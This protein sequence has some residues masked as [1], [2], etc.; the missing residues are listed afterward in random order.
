MRFLAFLSLFA[1]ISAH[2]SDCTR[3]SVGF[4]P[5]NELAAGLYKGMPGGFYP[6]GANKRPAAHE[7]AGVRLAGEVLPRDASGAVNQ[8][9]GRIVFIS[10]GMSNTT[11]EFSAFKA[12]ADRDLQKNPQLVIVDGAQGG[13]SA[14]KIAVA[15]PTATTYWTV[16]DQRL[17]AAGVTGAQVQAAWMKQA[18]AGPSLAFPADAQHLQA[19]LQSLAQ[20][21]RSRFPNLKLLYLSSRIYAG[22]ADTQLNPEPYAYQGS[23]A[24][25]WAIER[26]I[27]DDPTLSYDDGKAPWMAWGPYLWADGTRMRGDGLTYVCSD[28]QTDGTH[29]SPASQQRVANMLLDFLK[30][31]ATSRTW[32]VRPAVGAPPQVLAGALVNAAS[33]Q[34][35]VSAR[36]IASL[37][38]TGLASGTT[39]A[40][41]LPLP[42][43]LG[44]VSVEMDGV[45]VPLSYVS[46]TQINLL[47]PLGQ[48]AGNLV[49]RHDGGVSNALPVTPA[50]SA[51]GIF[52]RGSVPGGVAAALHADYSQI[53]SASPAKRGETI[54]LFITGLGSSTSPLVRIGG[55]NA[56]ITYAG[57]APGLPGVDQVNAIIPQDTPAGQPQLELLVSTSSAV[58]A[59]LPV[60]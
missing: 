24:V 19:E 15:S 37:F 11:Q 47:V 27:Q 21:M 4:T 45:P 40:S 43:V 10:V 18:D 31:D 57:P 39:G 5:L 25:K 48:T 56:T 3:V 50:N 59:V 58:P 7:A 23:F 32:F 29:P 38:G 1:V 41:A 2:A 17:A 35:S 14:D 28:L 53:S 6:S 30:S 9:S 44:G 49:V 22:Y 12:T 55:R 34:A 8:Q 26:Q 33:Y 52:T 16:V 36:S 20:T 60:S 51:P 13:M 54:M 42:L 46:A